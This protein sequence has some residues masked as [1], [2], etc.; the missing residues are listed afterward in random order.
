MGTAYLCRV[1]EVAGDLA[2]SV[3]PR[4]TLLE[5]HLGPVVLLVPS[6]IE[7]RRVALVL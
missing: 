3:L 1:G 2:L 7:S 4:G 6:A 5:I